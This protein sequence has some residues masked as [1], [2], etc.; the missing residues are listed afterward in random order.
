VWAAQNGADVI[1]CSWGPVDGAWFDPNDPQHDEVVLLP[2]STRLAMDFAVTQ[3]RNGKGCVILFAAG[4]GNENVGNDGYASYEKV[5]AV[6]A[7]NDLGKKSAYSDFGDAVWCAF[8]SNEVD[9]PRLTTGIWTTDNSGPLGYNPGQAAKG[10]SAGNYTNSFGGTSSACPGAAGVAALVI[11]R[12]PALRWDEVREILKNCCDK[13]D[14]AGGGYDANGRSPKY[15]FGRLNAKKAVELA[16]PTQPPQDRLVTATATQ[17]VPIRDFKTATLTLEVA[18]TDKLKELKVSVDI[19]HT[20]IGDLHVTLTPPEASGAVPVVLHKNTGGG[21]DNLR[22]T[23]DKLNLPALDAL[24]GASP[25]GTWTLTVKD[26]A[27]IDEGRIRSFSLEMR[28]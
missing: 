17:D 21:K 18:E 8:P 5:I 27:K 12:N 25:Q 26:T 22:T 7:C 23:Y 10:D 24:A 14:T 19:E 13:I 16:M 4:N 3:G 9:G 11:S 6:A 1:S 15:G 2:D 20:Y 28:L